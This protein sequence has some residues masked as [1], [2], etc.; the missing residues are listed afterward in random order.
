M[1]YASNSPT[2]ISKI[3]HSQNETHNTEMNQE[4]KPIFCWFRKLASKKVSPY[5]EKLRSEDSMLF[6]ISSCKHKLLGQFCKSIQSMTNNI[7]IQIVNK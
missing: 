1:K 7:Q 2:I 3:K 6:A 5:L 4:T